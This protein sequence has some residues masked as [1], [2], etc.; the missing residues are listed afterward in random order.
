M[1][2][3]WDVG[4]HP[5]YKDLTWMITTQSKGETELHMSKILHIIEIK[6]VLI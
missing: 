3:H 1:P 2:R 5:I 6:L 4:G